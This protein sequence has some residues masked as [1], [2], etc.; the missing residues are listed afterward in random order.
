MKPAS[1]AVGVGVGA[2]GRRHHAQLVEGLG[3]ALG[4]GS[5]SVMWPGLVLQWVVSVVSTSELV[6]TFV[7]SQ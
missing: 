7:P 3:K 1:A 5:S 6:I 2:A 4:M